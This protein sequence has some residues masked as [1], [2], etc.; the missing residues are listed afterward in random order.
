MDNIG[1]YFSYRDRNLISS[2]N[3]ELKNEIVQTM[4][5]LF[6]LSSTDTPVNVYGEAK[7]NQGKSFYPGI[8]VYC[9][10]ERSDLE[11]DDEGFGTD[12]SQD[13]EFRFTEDDLKTANFY[14]EMGDMVFFNQRYYEIENIFNDQQL[15]GGQP[16][17]NLSIIV[18]THYSR[19][20]GINVFNRQV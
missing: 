4:V 3:N 12:R 14:P 18:K 10:I 11:T 5:T 20:S 8:D 16:N 13:L 2:V 1:R 9:L 7:P 17:K 6:K 19:I 15:L